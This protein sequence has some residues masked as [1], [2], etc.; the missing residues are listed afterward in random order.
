MGSKGV[1]SKTIV[2]NVL[3]LLGC[4]SFV[5]EVLCKKLGFLARNVLKTLLGA[6]TCL[7]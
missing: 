2:E 5:F 3:L 7:G 6:E 4:V 1:V